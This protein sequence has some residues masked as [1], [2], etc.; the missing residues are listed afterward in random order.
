[1]TDTRHFILVKSKFLHKPEV[2]QNT[3]TPQIPSEVLSE[4][5]VSLHSISQS[6]SQALGTQNNLE[7][8]FKKKKTA[9]A[10]IS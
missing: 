5:T 2:I 10:S 4:G 8:Y 3:Q 6:Q 7:Y 1:M 9:T